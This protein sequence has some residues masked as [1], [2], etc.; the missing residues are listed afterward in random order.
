MAKRKVVITSNREIYEKFNM[1]HFSSEIV[2][3]GAKK[4]QVDRILKNINRKGKLLDSELIGKYIVVKKLRPV[5][6]T[7]Y[8][9]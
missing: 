9:K 1:L 2:L 6:F 5:N 7:I 4:I 3:Q 8:F